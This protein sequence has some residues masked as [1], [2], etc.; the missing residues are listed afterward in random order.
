MEGHKLLAVRFCGPD[1]A[2]AGDYTIAVDAVGAGAGEWVLTVTGS[3]ARE[4]PRTVKVST[5][6]T[7][8]SIVDQVQREGRIV[9]RKGGTA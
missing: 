4:D 2:S 7:I 3:S 8:V 6:T 1:G 9:Y 5:D